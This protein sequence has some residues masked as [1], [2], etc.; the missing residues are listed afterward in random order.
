MDQE[1]QT[2]NKNNTFACK[3]QKRKKKGGGGEDTH[4]KT[5]FCMQ[6]MERKNLQE[7]KT[8]KAAPFQ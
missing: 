5:H 2:Q 7:D 3:V 8:F 4:T 1:I 6:V